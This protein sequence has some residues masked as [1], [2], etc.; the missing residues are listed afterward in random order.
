MSWL[1]PRA[2]GLLALASALPC[3]A[4]QEGPV[5]APGAGVPARTE[6]AAAA[7]AYDLERIDDVIRSGAL[8]L[9]AML[10]ERYQPQ[11]PGAEPWLRWEE[12]L[13]H[14]YALQGRWSA[15]TA[16]GSALP[17]E[18]PAAVRVS[19]RTHV[20]EAHI[21]AGEGEA[22][23]RA[24]RELLWRSGMG[25]AD[26]AAW[27]RMVVRSYLADDLLE[28][29]RAALLRFDIEYRPD[30]PAWRHLYARVLLRAGYPDAAAE[31]VAALQTAEGRSLLLLARLRSGAYTPNQVIDGALAL[32]ND[33]AVDPRLKREIWATI[34]GAA[35]AAAN[36]SLRAEALERALDLAAAP[37]GVPELAAVDVDA[38]WSAYLALAQDVGNAA[39]LL[40][41]DHEPWLRQADELRADY[42]AAAR[43]VYA[44]LTS[45][46]DDA[47]QSTAHGQLVEAL[48]AADLEGVVAQL[49]GPD[50]RFGYAAIPAATRLRFSQAAFEAG[51][52][53]RAALLVADLTEPPVGQTPFEWTLRRARLS[54][55]AAQFDE[56]EAMLQALV[57]SVEE[58]EEADA[59]RLLQLVFD[60]QGAG[61]H[62]AAI[63]I[64]RAV[65]ERV[66]VPRQRRETLFW[67][68]DSR[69][70]RGELDIAA[71]LYLRSALLGSDGFDKW[72]QA[73][74]FQ[75]AKALAKLGLVGDARRLF[76]A[77]LVATDDPR[78]RA[79]IKQELQGIWLVEAGP[80]RP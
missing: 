52:V 72:G 44:L 13:I 24:L 69:G 7:A 47:I 68:A 11:P 61:R 67:L 74:R 29:A 79:L 53:A 63:R 40:I 2:L 37:Q 55:F 57:A 38:L 71:E 65:H 17:P 39:R 64:L 23:R 70:A 12:R 36:L 35:A 62:D 48:L 73:A 26:A 41:G 33:D 80:E 20:A 15:I 54:I 34:A 43:A 32:A 10:L 60:L 1:R 56:A 78:R 14:V 28:D 21:Q 3:S 76:E 75:A 46:D 58:F 31:Q 16:R 30:D 19:V 6:A 18:L 45:T 66:R 25:G 50:A 5:A 59:D 4:A 51:D 9:A 49:Y 22:A 27:R 42:P 77:L 8:E